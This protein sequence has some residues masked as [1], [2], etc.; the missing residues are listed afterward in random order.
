MS[1]LSSTRETIAKKCL[2]A[3]LAHLT[4]L[5]L[6]IHFNDL[7]C[8]TEPTRPLIKCPDCGISGQHRDALK[9]PPAPVPVQSPISPEHRRPADSGQARSARRTPFSAANLPMNCKIRAGVLPSPAFDLDGPK[10]VFPAEFQ[11]QIDL[12][13]GG[14][15]CLRPFRGRCEQRFNDETFPALADDGMSRQ[16]V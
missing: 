4:E 5:L 2:K 9:V 14:S 16:L 8:P 7:A 12:A 13:P 11:H 10:P 6:A 15:Y 1:I 3:K